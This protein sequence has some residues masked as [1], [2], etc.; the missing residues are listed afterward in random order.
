MDDICESYEQL[1][2]LID[3]IKYSGRHSCYLHTNRYKV[4]YIQLLHCFFPKDL[5][6]IIYEY[7]DACYIRLFLNEISETTFYTRIFDGTVIYY[8][9]I[10]KDYSVLLKCIRIDMF[11]DIISLRTTLNIAQPLYHLLTT[12]PVC[13]H[14][15]G[16]IVA[17]QNTEKLRRL[18]HSLLKGVY[19]I[20]EMFCNTHI[21]YL[22]NHVN[23]GDYVFLDIQRT[24][25]DERLGCYIFVVTNSEMKEIIATCNVFREYYA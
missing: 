6:L 16:Y 7:T 4:E 21:N 8:S 11:N 19:N 12:N 22:S 25:T 3:K 23:D 15:S 14:A 17:L 2:L 18:T 9:P 13:V 20:S 10:T 24:I 5:T 1:R